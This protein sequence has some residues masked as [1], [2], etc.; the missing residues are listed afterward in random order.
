MRRGAGPLN[1]VPGCDL[2]DAPFYGLLR[3]QEINGL[4]YEVIDP[5]IEIIINR[6]SMGIPREHEASDLKN[7]RRLT[8]KHHDVAEQVC[9]Y[10]SRFRSDPSMS[11]LLITG[12]TGIGKTHLAIGILREMCSLHLK[13]R[14]V[15]YRMLLEDMRGGFDATPVQEWMDHDVL[16]LDDFGCVEGTGVQESRVGTIIANRLA[17]QKPTIITTN[18]EF[19]KDFRKVMDDRLCSRIKA[20]YDFIQPLMA[21][22]RDQ[23]YA[24]KTGGNR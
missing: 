12:G 5:K 14:F 9:R 19:P 4:T 2:P 11:S 3:T 7:W 21:D 10:L 13:P 8:D 22:Y 20:G 23:I 24:R 15:D 16:C 18:L 1:K 6:K 17:D